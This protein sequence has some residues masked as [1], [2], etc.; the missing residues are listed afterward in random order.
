M[1]K[2]LLAFA[3]VF[4]FLVAW[5]AQAHQPRLVPGGALTIKVEN[6]ETS[7]AFYSELV[8]QIQV[9][10]INSDKDFLLYVNLLVPKT[11]QAKTDFWAVILK[12]EPGQA[13]WLGELDGTKFNWQE[14]YEKF[15]G[16]NYLKGP[17]FEK[18]VAAGKYFVR[19][20]SFNSNQGKYV[21][22]VGKEEK[23]TLKE[24]LN[25]I[26]LLPT[27]KKDFFGKSPLT[28]YFNLTGLFLLGCLV[29]LAGI[30]FGLWL[31]LRKKKTKTD[32]ENASLPPTP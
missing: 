24:I 28:A 27:L 23:F 18:E 3:V 14:F 8:G 1:K 16:D 21:L 15:T 19:V 6:P 32:E 22:A 9:Y 4:S 2:T 25:T 12:D 29:V 20:L 13:Q 26:K 10:E 17:E 7:Q 5:P 31:V 11:P 30:I